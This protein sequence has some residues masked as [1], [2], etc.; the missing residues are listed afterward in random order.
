MR[1]TMIDQPRYYVSLGD[2]M[3]IDAYAGGPGC[4]AASLL[5]KNR[6]ADF[7]EWTGRE[8]YTHFPTSRLIPL[9]TDGATS[10]TVRYWQL[11]RLQEMGAVP[12][13][14]TLT[15][16]GNDLVQCWLNDT[17]ARD[18]NRALR[19]NGNAILTILRQSMP[20]ESPILLGTI[21]DP[22]D[23]TGRMGPLNLLQWPRAVEWLETFN[24]TL[25]SLAREHG[26]LLADI[27]AHFLGHGLHAG[28]P[29]TTESRPENQGLWLCGTIEP[30]AWG[31]S[32]IRSLWWELLVQ[33]GFV[34]P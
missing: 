12:A 11:P 31:A 24:A 29:T 20:P 23:A 5:H 16:G 30:N 14:V 9:A 28:D 21:Y 6:T 25:H 22:S 19:E 13:I 10:A 4:G 1:L 3:S 26:I 18:A 32:A 33:S 15:M 17:A 8:L 2:S 27:H 7:P 34:L